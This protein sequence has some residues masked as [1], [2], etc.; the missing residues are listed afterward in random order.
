MNTMNIHNRL[1]HRH[2]TASTILASMLLACVPAVLIADDAQNWPEPINDTG[3]YTKLMFDRLEYDWG[4]TGDVVLWD[5]QFWHG[6]DYDRLWIETEGEDSATGKGGELEKLDVFYSHRFAAYWDYQLGPGY[7]LIY[8]PGPDRDRWFA[9]LGLQGLAPYWFEIDA[10][11]RISDDA[12][13]SV[14]LEAEYE[15]LLTQRLILQPRF[16]TAYAFNEVQEFGVGKGLNT[17]QFG[18][19]LRY[20]VRREFAPYIGISWTG[21]YGDTADLAREEGEDIRDTALVA[22]IRMWF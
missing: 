14:D 20:Q 1:T 6:G 10:N 2:V 4:D 16:E 8:G 15:W 3:R 13:A 5:A 17:L 19:R 22:G 7:Q 21:K 9:V 12:D 18:L 11:L